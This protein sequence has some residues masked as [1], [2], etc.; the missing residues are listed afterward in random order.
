MLQ[1][2]NCYLLTFILAESGSV[3]ILIGVSY[4][5]IVVGIA[6][7]WYSWFI[8]VYLGWELL[9]WDSDRYCATVFMIHLN[10]NLGWELLSWD[11]YWCYINFYLGWVLLSWDFKQTGLSCRTINVIGEWKTTCSRGDNVTIRPLDVYLGGLIS[12]HINGTV[13]CYWV[14]T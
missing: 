10:F 2:S 13:T 11:S 12:R 5:K 9:S 1:H 4:E 14:Q 8:D 7:R 3:G 6:L